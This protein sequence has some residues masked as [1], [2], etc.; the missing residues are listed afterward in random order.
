MTKQELIGTKAQRQARIGGS[1]F[2]TV[3]DINPYKKRIELVLE[4]AGVIANTFEGNDA[5][6][7]GE[8]LETDIIAK[9]EDATGLTVSN[10][11]QEFIVEPNDCLPLVCHVD[12]ITS[13]DAVFEEI[14]RAH[15]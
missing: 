13:D 3:M 14:G 7:R 4:K 1:E 12:G 6:R 9:F 10:E 5:T 2:A 11:Q 8:F 15:V